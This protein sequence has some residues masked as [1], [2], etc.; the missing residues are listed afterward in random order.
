V[1][2]FPPIPQDFKKEKVHVMANLK[3]RQYPLGFPTTIIA[4]GAST[5]VTANTQ[6]LFRG[7][8]LIVPSRIADNVLINDFKVGKN[9]Q[10]PSANPVPGRAFMETAVGV[11]LALDTAQ[12]A[13]SITLD[14]ENT[15]L[16]AMNFN[17]ALLGDAM[18]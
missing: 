4:A 17:A 11:D 1:G 7:R 9:S 8:R 15:S 16:A 12:V 18:E 10:F 5:N 14:V 6:V 13:Q 3:A 2:D